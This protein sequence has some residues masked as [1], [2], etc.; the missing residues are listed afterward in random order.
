MR[1]HQILGRFIEMFDAETKS[2]CGVTDDG[3]CLE[4]RGGLTQ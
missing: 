2:T 3:L 4:L 1:D